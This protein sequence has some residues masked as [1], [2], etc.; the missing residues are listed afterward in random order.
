MLTLFAVPKHFKGHFNIIQR[1]AIQSWMSLKSSCEIILFGDEEGT[2]EVAEEYG[3]RHCPEIARNE[4]GT[5]L[6]NDIFEKAQHLSTNKFFCFINADIILLSDFPKALN[7]ISFHRFLLA[8]QRWDMH[9]DHPLDFHDAAWET[10]LRYRLGKD[11]VLH[12]PDGIDYFVFSHGLW[13]KIPPFAIGRPA[14]DNW[15]IYRARAR[16]AAVID[17]TPVITAIHQNH[18]Y[19]HA[20]NGWQTVWEGPECVRNKA[21]AGCKDRWFTLWD[22][23]WLLTDQ[24]VQRS[25]RPEHLQRLEG[26]WKI[27]HPRLHACKEALKAPFFFPRR[28]LG[29]LFRRAKRYVSTAP[30]ENDT[31]GA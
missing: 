17:A 26:K 23:N 22:A 5:P 29:A 27:L 31:S 16:R 28:V 19:S 30:K 9:I 21:L 7:N 15:L 20:P 11:A 25:Q 8:G 13:G 12:T 24:G 10:K 3:A 4:F 14:Y 6:L 1:N 2:A 18:D